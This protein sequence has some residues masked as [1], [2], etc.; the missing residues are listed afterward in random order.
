[1]ELDRVG[2]EPGKIVI[3]ESGN[4]QVGVMVDEV[5]EVLT[6][7][8]EQLEDVPSA[9]RDSI[10]AIAKIARGGEKPKN[11]EGLDFFNTGVAL[12]T[13][14]GADGVASIDTTL[15]LNN[16]RSRDLPPP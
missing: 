13:D 16:V 10:E 15:T 9:N 7:S 1:M 4:G 12:V 8:S 6:V 5:E 11:S 3:V 2:S 14:K